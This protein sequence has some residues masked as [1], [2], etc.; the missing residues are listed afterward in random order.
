M[1][2]ATSACIAVGLVMFGEPALRLW[3]HRSDWT[4]SDFTQ[5]GR[6]IAIMGVALAI[7]LPQIGSRST[8][9]GVGRHWLVGGGVLER[10]SSRSPAERPRSPQ[11]GE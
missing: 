11:G 8:L 6:A 5:A 2:F 9:Q 10:A 3:L 7:G 1:T 4:D